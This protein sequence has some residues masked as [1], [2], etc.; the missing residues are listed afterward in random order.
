METK[1]LPQDNSEAKRTW[2]DILKYLKL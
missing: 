2:Y 1:R